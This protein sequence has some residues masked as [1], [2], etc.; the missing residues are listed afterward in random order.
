MSLKVM[1]LEEAEAEV[2]QIEEH[3]EEETI[4][5]LG[6]LEEVKE[7]EDVDE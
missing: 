2:M 3:L 5:D 7:V 6:C 1:I 4:I